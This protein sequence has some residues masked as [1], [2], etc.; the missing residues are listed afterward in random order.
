MN[1]RLAQAIATVLR[2]GKI[3]VEDYRAGI[4]AGIEAAQT[5]GILEDEEARDAFE[6]ATEAATDHDAALVELRRAAGIS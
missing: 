6:A 5:E 3:V 2:T 1:E 4:G